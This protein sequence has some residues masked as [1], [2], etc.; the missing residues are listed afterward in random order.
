MKKKTKKKKG[1]GLSFKTAP[2]EPRGLDSPGLPGVTALLR[3]KRTCAGVRA[4]VYICVKVCA[5]TL[6]VQMQRVKLK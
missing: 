5:N 3:G 6:C 2:E 1:F 4:W